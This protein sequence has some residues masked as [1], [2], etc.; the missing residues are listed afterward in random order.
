MLDAA[1]I[2]GG[3]GRAP[4]PVSGSD[5][6][7][8]E[9]WLRIDQSF[10]SPRT[11]PPIYRVRRDPADSLTPPHVLRT[12]SLDSDRARARRDK[13]PAATRPRPRRAASLAAALQLRDNARRL[14]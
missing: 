2:N 6:A 12:Q 11:P 14:C 9:P 3:A 1:G 10:R 13:S 5:A 7:P 4:S 8:R